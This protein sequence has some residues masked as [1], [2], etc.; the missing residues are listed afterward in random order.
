MTERKLITAEE[1]EAMSPDERATLIN[2]R[3]VTD[4]DE[5]PLEFHTRVIA[6]GQ[7]LAAERDQTT[8]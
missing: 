8:G 5:L 7:R 2:E 4:I 3:I 6:T 1:L